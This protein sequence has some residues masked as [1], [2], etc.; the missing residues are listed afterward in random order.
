[1]ITCESSKR[2]ERLKDRT[3]VLYYLHHDVEAAALHNLEL[4]C[5]N[6]RYVLNGSFS[7]ILI[8]LE[9]EYTSVQT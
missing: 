7:E 2:F 9:P 3:K 8:P 6:R 4:S 5:Y 1:M